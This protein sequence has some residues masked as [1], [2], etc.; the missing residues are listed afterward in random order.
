MAH[1]I[2]EKEAEKK[3][4][5]EKD[6]ESL[7]TSSLRKGD[8]LSLEHVDLVNDTIDE[9]GFTTYQAKLFCLNGFGLAPVLLLVFYLC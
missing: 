9:I 6:V 3:V 4:P 2:D 7:E 8:I 1:S 5:A